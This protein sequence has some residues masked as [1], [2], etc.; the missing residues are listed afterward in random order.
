MKP[1]EMLMRS[2]PL[3]VLAKVLID[4]EEGMEGNMVPVQGII[5][6][7]GLVKHAFRE[8]FVLI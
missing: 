1:K 6:I 5:A 4:I 7:K 2:C 3:I 8:Y